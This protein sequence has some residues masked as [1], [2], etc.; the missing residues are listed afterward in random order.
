MIFEIILAAAIVFL[1]LRKSGSL[2]S[3][4][5]AFVSTAVVTG[6]AAFAIV[7]VA[8]PYPGYSSGARFD[9]TNTGIA[10][11]FVAIVSGFVLGSVAAKLVRSRAE[12]SHTHR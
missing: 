6:L 1:M 8:R 12:I 7:E 2:K 5:L 9:A 11:W 10:V 4:L 3:H